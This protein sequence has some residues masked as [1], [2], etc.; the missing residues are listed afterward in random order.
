MGKVAS[1]LSS[2][3]TLEVK[4]GKLTALDKTI[5]VF[6]VL[7]FVAVTILAYNRGWLYPLQPRITIHGEGRVIDT[8]SYPYQ[9]Y[10]DGV[11]TYEDEIITY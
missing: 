6:I 7:W 2:L 4:K 5:I 11:I 9:Q 3:K 1:W 8:P 10:Q